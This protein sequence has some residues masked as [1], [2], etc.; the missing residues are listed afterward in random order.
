MPKMMKKADVELLREKLLLGTRGAPDKLKL[1][2]EFDRRLY[3][4]AAV[5]VLGM[6]LGLPEKECE[7]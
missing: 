2:N 4:I 3:R 7:G 5:H 6:V 1:T